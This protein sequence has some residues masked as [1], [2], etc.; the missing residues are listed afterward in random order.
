[1]VT[2]TG[3]FTSY[4]RQGKSCAGGLGGQP[5]HMPDSPLSDW[6]GFQTALGNH[7][8]VHSRGAPQKLLRNLSAVGPQWSVEEQCGSRFGHAGCPSQGWHQRLGRLSVPLCEAGEL[9]SLAVGHRAASRSAVGVRMGRCRRAAWV[10]IGVRRRSAQPSLS[11]EEC[12]LSVDTLALA[13]AIRRERRT[14]GSTT[15][16]LRFR[17][18]RDNTSCCRWQ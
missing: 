1:M 11:S 5:A 7:T 13:R 14:I 17:F 16:H 9:G 15:A 2:R 8:E 3:C 18:Q 10:L 4:E 6:A 12:G